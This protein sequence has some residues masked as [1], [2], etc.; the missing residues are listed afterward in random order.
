MWTEPPPLCQARQCLPLVA[1]GRGQM[2]CSHPH[3]HFSF[4]SRCELGCEEG[5]VLS[6]AP[7]LQCTESG[8]WSHTAP[9]CQ[10]RRCNTLTVP[11]HGSLSCYH[12]YEEFSFNSSCNVSCVEG[13]LL[14]GTASIQ[15]TS[16]GV[17]T[18][19]PPLCQARQCL[20]LV[21]PGR[22]QMNCSHPH[23]HFSFGSRCELGCE[24]G[25]VLRGAPTLQ[26]TESGLWSHTAP[27]CQA[28]RCN[29]LT[30]PFHG[31]LSCYHPYEKFSFN[32]SCS[33]S[34]VE[35]FL[36]NGT[37]SIQCTSLGMW[38]EPPPLCQARQCLPLVAPGRGQM[39]CS[40]PH[41]HFSFGS[42]CELG[43]EEGFV[44]RGAPT[45]QCTESGLWSHTTPS[46]QVVHCEPLGPLPP[47][48]AMKCYSP[49][50]NLSFSSQCLFH[51]GD[52]SSLNG[53][54]KM[55]CTSNGL[56]TTPLPSCTEL[57]MTVGIGMLKYAGVGFASGASLLLLAGLG[58]LIV[59][60]LSKR[61]KKYPLETRDITIWEEQENPAFDEA[62]PLSPF[63]HRRLPRALLRWC[64][65][66]CW[67]RAWA[68]GCL[69]DCDR[70]R[71]PPRSRVTAR[72]AT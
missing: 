24:E 63:S 44:L 9:S 45:L 26:C 28:R 27:S 15:C 22:G 70:P 37:A 51:C 10:A 39:N 8:L 33:V 3:S 31:S 32:S 69:L 7:T 11:F 43:C 58:F 56:W 40:H 30:V 35:G 17:W 54:A 61:G 71:G 34:C 5:F 19:P 2:N 66:T 14:N 16:L 57:E 38:T 72:D 53:T 13:F 12:P 50:G 60:H 59:S 29:T 52:G 6:G 20:P 49:L 47:H 18:E 68:L 62:S 25:F 4:G 55:S 36:L 67:D 65:I 64:W 23:S 41:S 48:L 1:P 21:A 42:R 46:C